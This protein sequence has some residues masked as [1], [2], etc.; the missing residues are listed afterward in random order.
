[1]SVN[2]FGMTS[3]ERIG[4]EMQIIER[5]RSAIEGLRNYVRKNT[6]TLH[7]EDYDAKDRKIRRVARPDIDTDVANKTYIENALKELRNEMQQ[8]SENAR[9]TS[10][11]LQSDVEELSRNAAS[12]RAET[13]DTTNRLDSLDARASSRI[14]DLERK[15]D[16][17][18]NDLVNKCEVNAVLTTKNREAIAELSNT[19]APKELLEKTSRLVLENQNDIKTLTNKKATK[20]SLD[21]M[22]DKV[23]IDIEKIR[24]AFNE[25]RERNSKQQ[26][27]LRDLKNKMV[28]KDTIADLKKKIEAKTIK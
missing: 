27:A 8:L 10:S 21:Q 3:S 5:T 1:M 23:S 24:T 28:T 17:S 11:R 16:A 2:K 15:C 7:G 12:W 22:K 26:N 19:K 9:K 4:E 18:H 20:E 13:R 25:L 14:N 6:L